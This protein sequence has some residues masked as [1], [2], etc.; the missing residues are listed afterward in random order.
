VRD[1]VSPTQWINA[2]RPSVTRYYLVTN[3]SRR[4]RDIEWINENLSEWNKTK[5][6][7]VTFD[8]IQDKGLVAL[9][10]PPLGSLSW[11]ADG[12]L[13]ELGP[14]PKAAKVLQAL[15]NVDLGKLYF[16]KSM[17]GDV[18][19]IRVHISRGG[20]TGEDGFEVRMP[21]PG[22][23][24]FEPQSHTRVNSS[25]SQP[26]RRKPSRADCS[27]IQTSNW[28]DS[29]RAI[30]CESRLASA[31]GVTISTRTSHR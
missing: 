23:A 3:A 30:A 10:G 24:P 7:N 5:G 20:Y 22:P 11:F 17:F 8:V 2:E 28:L 19:G 29:R 9:Q 21:L 16:G 18:D 4:A 31:C 6:T 1:A 15:T 25:R 14:G 12:C 13:K 27:R 26:S